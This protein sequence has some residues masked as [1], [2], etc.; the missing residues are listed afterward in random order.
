MPEEVILPG[1]AK[2]DY[3][4]DP[5]MRITQIIAKDPGSNNVMYQEYTYDKMGDI[6]SKSTEHGDYIYSYDNLRRLI[7]A[8]NPGENDEYYTYDSVGN[9]LTD[10]N[11]QY[12]YNE[13]NELISKGSITYQYDDN[14]NTIK[15]ED[16]S[17]TTK[18]IYDVDNRL[19]EVKDG[20]DNTIAEYYHDPFGR[21]LWKEVDG[22]RTYFVYGD[23]GLIAEYDEYGN[24][25]RSYGYRPDSG[26]MT[27]PVFMVFN[28][29]YYWYENGVNGTPY[30]LIGINGLVVWSGRYGGYGRC[31]VGIQSIRN[32][33]RYPGQYYDEETGLYYNFHRYYD[34]T[35]GRYLTPDPMK[36]GINPYIYAMNNIIFIDPYGY[37]AVKRAWDYTRY[38]LLFDMSNFFA[39]YGDFIT[40]G[41]TKWIRG[42]W[43]EVF[44]GGNDIV[45][46]ESGFYKAGRIAGYIWNLGFGITGAARSLG[47]LGISGIIQ[48][49]KT[50]GTAGFITGGGA[51]TFEY[52][53][54]GSLS[55]ALK[56]GIISGI[57]SAVAV[58]SRGA[59]LGELKSIKS[60]LLTA[61][62]NAELQN[63]VKGEVDYVDAITGAVAITPAGL[64]LQKLPLTGISGGFV[65]GINHAVTNMGVSVY[66]YHKRGD[67]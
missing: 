16:T 67:I 50:A 59:I 43:N 14:G 66:N 65:L 31:Y 51:F 2:R 23:E 15:I 52:A 20:D 7:M 38:E 57:T 28:G 61:V 60:A 1:G 63:M 45:D 44:W 35:T 19:I 42:R 33:L 39:A 64:M 13:N 47:G 30:K 3:R 8:D 32:N 24:E 53:R 34:P 40:I 58:G 6:L 27:D 41:G 5:L 12:T 49:L 29:E 36:D 46:Y 18:F 22:V 26:W 17:G 55:R 54:T 9:R 21:R 62:T 25:I 56:A 48:A 10:V 11:S 37:C 4:Y